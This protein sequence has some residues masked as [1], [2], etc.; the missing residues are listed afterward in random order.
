[1]DEIS[2]K[3]SQV[4]KIEL[5]ILSVVHNFCSEH[6]LKY[7]LAYG[8]LLGA[9]RH[10]GF[11]PWD[12]DIDIW[13]PREDYKKFIKL[14][15]NNPVEGY[16]LQTP[17][18]EPEFT[19]NFSKIRKN[20][21]TYLQSGEEHLT[22]HK[23]IFIDIFPLDRIAATSFKRKMQN[24]DAVFMMLYARKFIPENE[25]GIKKLIS[26]IALSVIPKSMYEFLKLKFEKK[27]IRKSSQSAGYKYFG[28]MMSLS[29]L[30]Y[31]SNMFEDM[32]TLFFEHK[33][34]MVTPIYNE[35]LTKFYGD[36]MKLPP[37]DQRVWA[38]H[39]VLIDFEN[40][41]EDIKKEV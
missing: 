22:Y 10:K 3:L 20:N 29:K 8:T 28:S 15:S 37:V 9:V 7:S 31:S 32:V 26:K 14:W 19:Q 12:D 21:T 18:N 11:I 2:K 16:I 24:L 6:N 1:M 41:I 35:V 23:G 40:N 27:I 39:P 36:Y 17:Y 13:M 4:K 25:T 38:H 33:E 5:E 34:F 30:S